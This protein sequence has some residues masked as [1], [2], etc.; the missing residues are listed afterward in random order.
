MDDLHC[1]GLRG[2]ETNQAVHLVG[3]DDPAM[4]RRQQQF[5]AALEA[6]RSGPIAYDPADNLPFGKAWNTAANFGEPVTHARWV[7]GQLASGLATTVEVPYADAKGRAITADDARL[8]GRDLA[9]AVY[10]GC[11]GVGV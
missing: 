2:V 7:A 5:S 1:P 3:S 6:V 10:L 9:A 8:L 11:K 4:W